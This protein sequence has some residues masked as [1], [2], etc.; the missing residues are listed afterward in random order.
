[1]NMRGLVCAAL[2]CVSV[3][4]FVAA[5]LADEATWQQN[6]PRREQV[7]GRLKNENQRIKNQEAKGNLSAAQAAQL[8]KSEANIGKE[9]RAMSSQNGGHL[10]KQQQKTLNQQENAVSKEI[11]K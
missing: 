1:M 10:T 3:A 4:G 11:P 8:H 5:A 9:E 6:H 2:A 7:N